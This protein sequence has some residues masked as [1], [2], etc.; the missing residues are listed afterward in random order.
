MLANI[1]VKKSKISGWGVF[2]RRNF[3]K[4]ETVIKWKKPKIITQSQAS[5]L[6]A[7]E[8][9]YLLEKSKN[10][11]ILMQVPERFVNHSCE[12]NTRIKNSSDVAARRIKKGE[13]II[14][15]FFKD[16]GTHIINEDD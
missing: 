3:K 10:R 6:P 13:E 14:G 12:A 7:C 4:G 2:A 15:I 9:H 8:K 1:I 16:L 5:K 11:F